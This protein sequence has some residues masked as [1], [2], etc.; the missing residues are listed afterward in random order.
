M[1]WNKTATERTTHPTDPRTPNATPASC[2]PLRGDLPA[3][4]VPDLWGLWLTTQA[5]PS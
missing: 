1:T 5:L 2:D 4:S 3:R